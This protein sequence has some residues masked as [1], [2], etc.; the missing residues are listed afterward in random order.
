MSQATP[1]ASGNITNHDEITAHYPAVA[2]V[3]VIL[4]KPTDGTATPH[5]SRRRPA[6]CGRSPRSRGVRAVGVVGAQLRCPNYAASPPGSRK[7]YCSG[8]R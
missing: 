3:I 2:A 6:I 4:I 7:T 5:N 8:G 1:L